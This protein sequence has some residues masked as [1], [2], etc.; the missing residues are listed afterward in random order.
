[1]VTCAILSGLRLTI[2]NYV[3]RQKPSARTS[4]AE[5]I[6]ATC[7]VVQTGRD[8]VSKS[9]QFADRVQVTQCHICAGW[10]E[11]VLWKDTKKTKK[12]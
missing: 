10:C 2:S 1:M 12:N 3:T 5:A 8:L 6:E 4:N 7:I 9:K 11:T